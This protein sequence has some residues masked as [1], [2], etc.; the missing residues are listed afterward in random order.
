LKAI[1][2]RVSSE[3]SI[4][5]TYS[6]SGS[7]NE[8]DANPRHQGDPAA[9]AL[10]GPVL[11]GMGAYLVGERGPELFIPGKDG[12]II[13]ADQTRSALGAGGGQLSSMAVYA[14]QVMVQAP[15]VTIGGGGSITINQSTTTNM[16]LSVTTN[17]SPAVI[18]QSYYTA[19]ALAGA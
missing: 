11:A 14:Q 15:M 6:S 18:Q 4:H 19:R 9:R 2:S 7:R 13:T 5:T 1:P 16:P 10:G 8:D 17:Q 12:Q 3:V